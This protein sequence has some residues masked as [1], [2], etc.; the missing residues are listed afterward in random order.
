MEDNIDSILIVGGGDAGLLTGLCIRQLN[1]DVSIAIVDD[2]A[3]SRSTLGKSTFK[4]IVDILHEFLEIPPSRFVETVKPVWKGS[5]FFRDWCGLPPFHFPFDHLQVFP[6]RLLPNSLAHDVHVYELIY[7]TPEY[8]TTNE[9]MVAQQRTPYSFSPDGGLDTY[10]SFA[11]HLSV[12]RFNRFLRTLCAERNIGLIDDQITTVATQGNHVEHLSSH[13]ERYTADLY[14]DATGFNRVLRSELD[15]SFT[16]F[17]LPLDSAV[18]TQID[19]S[20]S[21]IV[22]ATVIETGDAGWYWQID[23]YDNRDVGYVF[24]S[25][26]V[27]VD[28]AVAE[29]NQHMDGAISKDELVT[30]SFTSGY[31]PETWATNCLAI[32]NAAGFVEPLQSTG[33]TAN[34]Q[35]AVILSTLL[36]SHGRINDRAI[37][38]TYNTCVSRIWESIYDFVSLHYAYAPGENEFWTDMRSVELS[39]RTLAIVEEFQRRGFA[40]NIDPTEYHEQINNLMIFPL[41]TYYAIMRSMGA[42]SAF[43]EEHDFDS[44]ADVERQWTEHFEQIKDRVGDFLSYEEFYLGLSVDERTQLVPD[45]QS[46]YFAAEHP[47]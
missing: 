15:G 13:D 7:T 8:R 4:L 34:A 2:S 44:T 21:S 29:F 1:P 3:D 6:R 41:V 28:D 9:E 26:H 25:E 38:E 10:S 18:N 39:P 35:A 30:Y 22:P 23:T 12:E 19:L 20:L 24:S 33:L 32:G 42:T 14:I 5:V 36:S 47:T 16:D 17:G 46:T 43:Y 11:Y 37:R 27:D 40:T 45:H 31:Y